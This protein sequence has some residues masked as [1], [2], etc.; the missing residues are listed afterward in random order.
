MVEAVIKT[1]IGLCLLVLCVFLIVWVLGEIGIV[2]PAF[3][4]EIARGL[5]DQRHPFLEQA[6]KSLRTRELL[7]ER[8]RSSASSRILGHDATPH[9]HAVLVDYRAAACRV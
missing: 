8:N 4:V 5:L 1:L 7:T 9:T 2:L 6:G 3:A